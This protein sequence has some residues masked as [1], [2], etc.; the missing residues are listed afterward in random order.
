MVNRFLRKYRLDTVS[1]LTSPEAL[2]ALD[3]INDAKEEALDSRT[4]TF[5]E[6]E[7]ALATLPYYASASTTLAATNGANI[8][9]GADAT[10]G[11]TL[12]GSHTLRVVISSSSDRA[13]TA[14]ACS[15]V[16]IIGGAISFYLTHA[17]DGT[18]AT[19]QTAN[20]FAA[21][22]QF[23]SH[24]NGDS[25]VRQLL[26]MTHQERPLRLIEIDKNFHFDRL[27]TRLHDS[28]GSDPEVVYY[29]RPIY[30]TDSSVSTPTRALRSGCII[31]PIPTSSARLDYTYR[32]RHT[33][34]EATTDTLE[35]VPENVV[36]AIV[37]LAYGFSL[38]TK[39][40]NDPKLADRVIAAATTRV[41]RLHDADRRTPHRPKPVPSLDN[42][43]GNHQTGRRISN[44]LI[45]GY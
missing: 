8:A 1:V 35:G 27:V 9:G 42:V 20:A 15:G 25:Q 22:Y 24:T 5:D 31:W 3:C 29:G 32:Y 33:R 7:D 16:Q 11:A 43:G 19:S 13:N 45:V 6:R 12:D 4:W 40:G 28:I 36:N 14:H 30:S 41:Q 23:P 37:E 39:F 10:S 17:W 2:A 38:N 34:L 21:E 18:T 44:D 26:S